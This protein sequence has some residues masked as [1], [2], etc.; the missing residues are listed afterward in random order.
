MTG[1]TV[2]TGST[3]KFSGGW[4]HI[5][6]GKKAAKPA[7][8]KGKAVAKKTATAAAKSTG[9]PAAKKKRSTK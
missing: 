5:F 7:A 6:S 2:H 4:D 1:Y 9:K 3:A 8:A